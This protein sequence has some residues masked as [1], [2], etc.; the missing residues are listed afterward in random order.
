[1]GTSSLDRLPL[2][3]R[4]KLKTRRAIQEHAMRLFT[5]HGY[6]GTTVEQIADAAEVSPSTFFRYFPT[7]EDV[8]LTDEYDELME[9]LFQARPADEPV[10]ESLRQV[11]HQL[12]TE[13]YASDTEHLLARVKLIYSVP[14]LRARLMDHNRTHGN[15]E[16][17]IGERIGRPA[18][19]LEIKLFVGAFLG[20]LQV[21]IL[22]WV[23]D[24]GTAPLPA[25]IENAFDFLQAGLPLNPP[26]GRQRTG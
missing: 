6:D 8:V 12:L 5:E 26:A 24:G 25:L 22:T 1:M 20:L 23:E 19:A 15:I 10:V 17:L 16:A 3:E 4:K 9:D 14:A 21:V 7:K 13:M 11:M 2:R 18:D